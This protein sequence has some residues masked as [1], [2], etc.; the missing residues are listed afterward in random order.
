MPDLT[1]THTHVRKKLQTGFD[2]RRN[3][4]GNIRVQPSRVLSNTSEIIPEKIIAVKE[5]GAFLCI[6]TFRL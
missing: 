2:K 5:I 1:P 4:F 3:F 6:F